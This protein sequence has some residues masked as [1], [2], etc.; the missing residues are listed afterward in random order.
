MRAVRFHE[1]G[2]PGVLR[3]DEIDAPSVG[4]GQVVIRTAAAAANILDIALREGQ[5]GALFPGGL[6][7]GQGFDLAGTIVEVSGGR[8]RVRRGG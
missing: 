5:M 4:A 2:G 6:P 8:H 7:S 1:Y 3:V